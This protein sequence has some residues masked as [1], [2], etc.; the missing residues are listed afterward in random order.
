MD[1]HFRNGRIH[2]KQAAQGQ[3]SDPS[4]GENSMRS[5]LSFRGKQREGTEDQSQCSKARGEKIQRESRQQDE[6]DAN[7]PGNHRTGMVELDVERERSYGQEKEG[8][9]W[10]HQ[11]VEDVF[12]QSHRKRNHRLSCEIQGSRFPGETFEGFSLHLAEEIFGARCHV[13]DKMPG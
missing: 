1:A 2:Q 10:I 6:D 3:K 13:V 4:D 7:G 12:L 9:V 11:F 5:E 8:Y